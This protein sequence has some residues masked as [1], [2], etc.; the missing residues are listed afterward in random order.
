MRVLLTVSY[1]GTLFCGWQI[2]EGKRTVQKEIEEALFSVFNREIRV[3]AS[4]R[5]DSGVHALAQKAHFDVESN[6]PADKIADCLNRILPDDV[7]IVSSEEVG[8]DFDANRTAKRKTYCYSI[9]HS[10]KIQPLKERYAVKYSLK[11][12]ISKMREAA[13]IL[14]GEHD[15]KAFCASGSTV[16]TTVRTIYKIDIAEEKNLLGHELKIYVCGN[17]FL[18]NMVRSIAGELLDISSG[19]LSLESLKTALETGDRSLIGKTMPAKGL[20]LV[21]V[22]Y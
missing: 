7:K 8:A 9:Y 15:F 1:D 11:P 17:G 2:Q 13:D 16:K 6:I 12:N 21:D 18:Y 19:R 10:D 5:T 4:G 20:M 22:V 14:E 3:T